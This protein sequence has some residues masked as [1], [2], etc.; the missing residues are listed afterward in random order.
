MTMLTRFTLLA[1]LALCAGTT[2]LAAPPS[3]ERPGFPTQA[4]VWIENRGDQ[5]AIPIVLHGVATPT[6]VD[7][8]I[9]GTAAVTLAGPT[10]VQARLVRQPWE[11]R[12]VT[13]REGQDVADALANAGV[14]GWEAVGL[15]PT[16]QA[17][18][19][20]LLKRPRP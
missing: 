4:R 17:G 14:E 20:L 13:V 18:T 6:P 9:V 19:T 5:E 1:G 15:Q 7:T 10:L 3:Q 12:T 8:R 16:S 11:Y 2:P